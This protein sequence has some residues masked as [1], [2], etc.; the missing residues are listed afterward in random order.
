MKKIRSAMITSAATIVAMLPAG[1]AFAQCFTDPGTG[2]TICSIP[3]PPPPQVLPPG[4]PPPALAPDNNFGTI[5]Q[6]MAASIEHAPA[7][8]TGLSYLFALLLG[9]QGIVKIKEHVENPAQNPLKNS[10]VRLLAGGALFALP[11]V[12]EAMFETIG[13]TDA[14]V[15]AAPL[16]VAEFNVYG[17]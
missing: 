13:P 8:L 10:A 4:L 15:S 1:K 3:A 9:A 14:S 2:L 17:P 16:A 12:F 11:I 7:L 6:N 5:A